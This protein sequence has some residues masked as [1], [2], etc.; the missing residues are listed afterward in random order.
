MTQHLKSLRRKLLFV[1]AFVAALIAPL[2]TTAQ[3]TEG[4]ATGDVVHVVVAGPGVEGESPVVKRQIRR[5]VGD[6]S[7]SEAEGDGPVVEVEK[8]VVPVEGDGDGTPGQKKIRVVVKKGDGEPE[9]REFVV[10][11]GAHV[12]PFGGHLAER[13][14]PPL[15]APMVWFGD[16]PRGYLGVELTSLTPELRRHFGATEETGVLVGRVEPDSPA[17]RA[18]L[19]V[20]DVLTRVDGQPVGSTLDVIRAIGSMQD[21]EIVALEIVRGGRVETLSAAVAQ[22]EVPRL[23][24]GPMVRRFAL[25][26]DEFEFDLEALSGK[27]ERLDEYFAGPEWKAQV[28]RLEGLGTDLEKRLEGLEVELERLENEIGEVDVR[29]EVIEEDEGDEERQAP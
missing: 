14:G 9:V 24:V 11:A 25:E 13:L 27:M 21:G 2:L 3:E 1:A 16:G 4:A 28:E 19:R 29:V 6:P 23:D 17:E 5:V 15:G 18:G 10:P 26:G 20:G 22:R 12:E 8:I 7:T